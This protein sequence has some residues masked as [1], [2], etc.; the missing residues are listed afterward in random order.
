M[1]YVKF[2]IAKDLWDLGVVLAIFAVVVFIYFAIWV[3]DRIKA[4]AIKAAE[5]W[6]E[7]HSDRKE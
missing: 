2:W 3:F 1:E 5:K 7:I 4:K 6:N